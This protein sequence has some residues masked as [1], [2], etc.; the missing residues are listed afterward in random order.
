MKTSWS[1][2]CHKV[3]ENAAPCA[4]LPANE[5]MQ[6]IDLLFN[7]YNSYDLDAI[8]KIF[9]GYLALANR[10][11]PHIKDPAYQH[12]VTDIT[13]LYLALLENREPSIENVNKFVE[14]SVTIARNTV[15]RCKI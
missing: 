11:Q 5:T 3:V 1:E 13:D 8:A 7:S 10:F 2:F 9:K 12:A 15:D 4:Q 14:K 6:H